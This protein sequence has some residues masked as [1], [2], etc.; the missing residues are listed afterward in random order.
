MGLAFAV[1]ATMESIDDNHHRQTAI[2][3]INLPAYSVYVYYV[4]YEMINLSLVLL[5]KIRLK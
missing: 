1:S 2:S 4:H 3:I 5:Y